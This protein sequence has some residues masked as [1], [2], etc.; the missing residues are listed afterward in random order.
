MLIFIGTATRL[1]ATRREQRFAAMR[2]VGATPR[3]ISL[4]SA[5]ESTLA[6]SVGTAV[7]FGLFFA[8]RPGLAIIPFTGE[9]FFPGDL[10]LTIVNVLAVALGV[11][12]G[13]VVASWLALRRVQISPLGVSRRV[14]PK[15]P[16]AWRLIPLVAGSPR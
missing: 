15:P 13:A 11:P 16:R 7:G 4:I 12:L 9:P 1:A 8:A 3:Q 6:A 10:S 2:L 5:V 14:T